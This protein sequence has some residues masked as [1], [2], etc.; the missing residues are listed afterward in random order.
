MNLEEI[1]KTEKEIQNLTQKRI[2]LIKKLKQN[3]SARAENFR[4][5]QLEDVLRIV[6]REVGVEFQSYKK[7]SRDVDFVMTKRIYAYFAK[8]QT[9]CTL[10]VIGDVI[11]VNHA[12][13]L[14]YLRTFDGE[15]QYNHDFKVIFDNVSN[16]LDVKKE[17][18]HLIS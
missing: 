8:K 18:K 11:G 12:T 3:K 7:T 16:Y 6:S 5:E 10:K 15:L 4:K 1:I 17:V 9:S 2:E 14:H 13:V